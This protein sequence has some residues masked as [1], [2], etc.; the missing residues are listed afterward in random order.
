V[1]DVFVPFKLFLE[2]RITKES[3]YIMRA[4]IKIYFTIV[5]TFQAQ[6]LF[7]QAGKQT[8]QQTNS[9]DFSPQPDYTDRGVTTFRRS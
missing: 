5:I 7:K 9:V 6:I 3:A 2:C 4:E 8:N 1:G